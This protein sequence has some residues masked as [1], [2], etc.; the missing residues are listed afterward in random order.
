MSD[1]LG[2]CKG[3]IHPHL[4]HKICIDWKPV[5]VT[6]P[7]APQHVGTGP[8]NDAGMPE[9]V[10]LRDMVNLA[11]N[12]KCMACG[13]PLAESQDK[14]CMQGNC[15]YRPHE[16]SPDYAGWHR[17]QQLAFRLRIQPTSPTSAHA[18]FAP[19]AKLPTGGD[20]PSA[21]DVAYKIVAAWLLDEEGTAAQQR[22]RLVSDI[23][24]ALVE[25]EQSAWAQAVERAA[26]QSLIGDS[27][28]LGEG[29][30][31]I[32]IAKEIRSLHRDQ[33]WLVEH[34]AK[35]RDKQHG[36]C[37]TIAIEKAKEF[38]VE[39]KPTRALVVAVEQALTSIAAKARLACAR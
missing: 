34:D 24:K 11:V 35:V 27:Q 2:T 8:G 16:S 15:S 36:D 25:R 1:E 7:P 22:D 32:R 28:R 38:G 31:R 26:Q 6:A 19:N 3:F 5:S 4:Q 39:I 9:V 29:E 12:G 18:P 10:D 17:R 21:R 20:A 33:N 37:A 30:L 23:T 14:G 13:W